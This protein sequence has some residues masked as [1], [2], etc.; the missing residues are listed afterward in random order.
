M[1]RRSFFPVNLRDSKANSKTSSVSANKPAKTLFKPGPRR[2]FSRWKWIPSNPLDAQSNSSIFFWIFQFFFWKIRKKFEHL[3]LNILSNCYIYMGNWCDGCMWQ[4]TW[5][6]CWV[7]CL[8]VSPIKFLKKFLN[9][10]IDSSWASPLKFVT[11]VVT[12]TVL[13]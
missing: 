1:R 7:E 2:S 11:L 3:D 8:S 9:L 4:L 10:I 6:K 13:I 12:Y 5:I